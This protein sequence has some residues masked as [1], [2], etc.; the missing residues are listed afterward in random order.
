MLRL[1]R[2]EKISVFAHEFDDPQVIFCLE[3]VVATIFSH[4]CSK[5]GAGFLICQDTV[6]TPWHSE[7][8]CQF[9]HNCNS[10]CQTV[11]SFEVGRKGPC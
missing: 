5:F 6:D 8:P 3:S 4:S 9:H 1:G 10:R 7:V 11:K 2:P